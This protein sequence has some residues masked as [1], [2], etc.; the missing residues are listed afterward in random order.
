MVYQVEVPRARVNGFDFD[1]GNNTVLFFG[2]SPPAGTNV[3]AA[4]AT[5]FYIN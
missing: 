5:F 1:P 3:R 4:F 2:A